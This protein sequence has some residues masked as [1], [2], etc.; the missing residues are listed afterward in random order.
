MQHIVTPR[1]M[2]YLIRR[3]IIKEVASGL[4]MK[5]ISSHIRNPIFLHDQIN[6]AIMTAAR[7]TSYG[8]KILNKTL[9]E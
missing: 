7:D 3:F 1:G 6:C 9:K 5:F 2:Y 8:F 4:I